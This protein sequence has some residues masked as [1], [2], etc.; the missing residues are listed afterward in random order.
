MYWCNMIQ[1]YGISK[2]WRR[3]GINDN[4]AE[5][6]NNPCDTHV[7]ERFGKIDMDES[8]CNK[9]IKQIYQHRKE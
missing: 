9:R 2:Q 7:D 4:F 6:R 8:A 1:K 3:D 5:R